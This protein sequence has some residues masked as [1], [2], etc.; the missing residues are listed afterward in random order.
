[1]L[2][3]EASRL[4]LD[5]LRDTAVDEPHVVVPTTPVLRGTTVVPTT[6]VLRSTTGVPQDID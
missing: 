1:M 3:R 4:I 2:G 5:L 6:P